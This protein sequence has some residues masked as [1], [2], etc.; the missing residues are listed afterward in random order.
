MV[1]SV[2]EQRAFRWP[3]ISEGTTLS[4]ARG[5]AALVDGMDWSRLH[6]RAV[7]PADGQIVK[8]AMD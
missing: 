3:R 6:V 5:V 1:L 7:C 2:L 8:V 4:A